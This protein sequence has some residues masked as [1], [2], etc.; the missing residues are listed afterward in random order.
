MEFLV[1]KRGEGYQREQVDAYI[2]ELR[3]TYQQMYEAHQMMHRQY[4]D[5]ERRHEEQSKR[6]RQ[7]EGDAKAYQ[8]QKDAIAGALIQAQQAAQA[9]LANARAEADRRHYPGYPQQQPFAIMG[10]QGPIQGMGGMQN[11]AQGGIGYY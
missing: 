7:L 1:D 4:E 6:M 5:L 2:R 9:V 8:T 3:Q 10:M 11:N